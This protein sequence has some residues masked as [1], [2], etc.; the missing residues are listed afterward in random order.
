MPTGS[1]LTPGGGP[2]LSSATPPAAPP[3]FRDFG[4]HRATRQFVYDDVLEA[5]NS[6]E[7]VSDDRYTLTLRDAHYVDPEKFTRK[8][9]K[10][11]ILAGETLGRRLKGTWELRDNASGKVLDAREQVVARVPFL[12][13]RG[14][15]IHRGSEYTITNQQ[16]L[17][18]GV[19]TRRMNN[20]QLESHLNIMPGKGLSH[21]YFLD[22]EKETFK[23]KVGQAEMPLLP[24]LRAMGATDEQLREAWGKQILASNYKHDD[25]SVVKKL[26]Q[27]VLRRK[28]QSDDEGTTRQRLKEAFEAMELDEG[29][30]KRTLGRPHKRLSLDAMLDTTRKLLAVSRGEAEVDDRD[31]LAYQT[32][33]G[34]E[35]FFVERLRKDHSKIRRNLL[36]KAAASGNLSKV[37]AGALT[38]QLEQALLGSGLGQAIEEINPLEIYDKQSRVSRLGEGGIPSSD[39]VPDEARSVSPSHFGFLDPLRTPESQAV[40][41]DLNVARNARKG[42][43][44]RLYGRFMDAR[45][46]KEVW[47]S[48]QD[49]ADLSIAFPG[50]LK[51]DDKRVPALRGG[52]I[53]YVPRKQVDLVL[54]NFE[55]AFSP[56]GN[57]VPLKSMVKGQRVAMASRMLTQAL[58]LRDG[59]APLVQGAIPGQ[60]DRSFEEEYGR[61]MGAVRADKDGRVISIKDGVVKVKFADGTVDDIEL[62]EAFPFNRKSLIH[63]TPL[64]QPGQTFKA[65]Q[66]LVRS[67]FTDAGGVAAPGINARVAYMPW[68]GYNFEDALVISESMAKRLSSEHAYQHDLEV[69]AST[70]T[71]KKNY[72]SLFPQRFDKKTLEMLDDDGVIKPGTTVEYGQPLI[73]AARQKDS[74]A[75]KIHKRKQQG[76]SDHAVLWKHHDPGVVTDVVRGKKGPVVLVRSYSQ[77]QVGDKM[78][79]DAET[80]ILTRGRGWVGVAAV[81]CADEVATLNPETDKLEWQRPTHVWAYDHDGTMYKLVVQHVDMLVTT[82][83]RLWV[84]RPGESYRAMEAGEFF[85]QGGT[86]LFKN[87]DREMVLHKGSLYED[88]NGVETLPHYS[89]KVY[90]VTVPNHIVLVARNGLTHWSMNSGRYGDKGVVSH[91]VPD[92]QMPT[93]RD[94]KPFEVLLNP[95]GVISRCYDERT[96]FLTDRGWQ[97]GRDVL[98]P[99]SL[100]CFNPDRHLLEWHRQSAPMYV[101][102]YSGPM[103]HLRTRERV[104]AFDLLVTPNHKMLVRPS[105]IYPIRAAQ[106]GRTRFVTA[107]DWRR[108]WLHTTAERVVAF[109]GPVYLPVPVRD[110]TDNRFVPGD[111]GVPN[112]VAYR[113]VLPQDWAEVAYAGK[114]Y[115]PT[116]PTGYVVVRR[117]GRVMIAGNTNPAQMVE[118]MLGKIAE[119]T[120]KPIKVPDFGDIED[121]TAWAQDMLRK[122]ELKDTDDV[123]IPE[124]GV[125]VGGVATGNRFFLKLHHTSE[126][127]AQG[128]SGGSYSADETPS[129]GGETGCFVYYTPVTVLLDGQETVVPLGWLAGNRHRLPI[130]TL[131]DRQAAWADVTDHFEYEVDE[132]QLLEIELANGRVLAVTRNHVLY[133]ADGSTKL[134]S[135]IQPEDDLLEV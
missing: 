1:L 48:P 56:I 45:T 25:P 79:F 66:P 16:R 36:R 123:T 34:P 109:A 20:G 64:V 84:A 124:L 22:P 120:G 97:F 83:H 15:F 70:R 51:G 134:A 2:L 47:R 88:S 37:P 104:G 108:H 119:R 18:P 125:K 26:A 118:A 27:R 91:I 77:M 14:T 31:H 19:F 99:D 21:R 8:Q 69:D 78:C 107:A 130:R 117:R 41:I 62:Y 80:S 49:I 35:D 42:R 93:D 133:M 89:G 96:E 111:R 68:K 50:A 57:L 114:V 43:D 29:V 76:F 59:Q 3:Q 46:G 73:L 67:N 94:G 127:K 13:H 72:V 131:A 54:P 6:L 55:D 71:G 58:A 38:A 44:G 122:H 82:N 28:D 103:L 135:Q 101:G 53:T 24:L 115:C 106:D 105:A 74:S 11:A 7:P 90:C 132:D 39:S 5:A 63:Q 65:G 30:T 33:L 81:T 110:L 9:Q 85:E 12:T 17:L 121:M 40:G 126:G 102:D 112:K 23:L 32:F 4:D 92:Q 52:K 10:Q 60:P 98:R 128:R 86:W 116:V 95:L 113:E 75:G 129:K 61:H 100:L 87:L